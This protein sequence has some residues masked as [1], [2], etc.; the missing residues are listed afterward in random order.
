MKKT[1]AIAAFAASVA[2]S[3]AAHAATATG[4]LTVQATVSDACSVADSTLTFGAVNPNSGVIIPVTT[5]INVTCTLGTSFSVGLGDGSNVS[6]GNRRLRR[7]AT[8]DYLRYELY[9]DLLMTA[10]FGDTGS[11]DRAAGLGLGIA[12]TPVLVYG[13]IPSSQTA[14][15]GSYAD[16]VQITLYY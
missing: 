11:S 14:A 16:S 10:R 2:C 4:T 1:V 13:A 15:S 6:G 5:N 8:S 12:A 7:G 3:S 9:K